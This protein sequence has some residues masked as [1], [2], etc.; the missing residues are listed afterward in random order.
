MSDLLAGTPSWELRV[1]RTRIL[2]SIA[3][4]TNAVGT[5]REEKPQ[6]SNAWVMT[7]R[8]E[9]E[10]AMRAFQRELPEAAGMVQ[11]AVRTSWWIAQ[12]WPR[13]PVPW[14]CLMRL[15]CTRTPSVLGLCNDAPPEQEWLPRGPWELL[16]QAT[17]HAHLR[18]A[19]HRM[20]QFLADQPHVAFDFSRW[21]ASRAPRGSPLLV[22]PLY[23]RT[24]QY[25][26][27]RTRAS[28]GEARWLNP[29]RDSVTRGMAQEEAER[30]LSG[31]F[32]HRDHSREPTS[33]LDLSYLAYA[34][35]CCAEFTEGARVFTELGPYMTRQPWVYES[36]ENG[37]TQTPEEAF[38]LARRQ[39]LSYAANHRNP[40]PG[41]PRWPPHP[42]H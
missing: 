8:V 39:C 29:W 2:G 4:R 31:W 42:D 26:W 40:P 35:W 9:T 25:H 36:D 20:R 18:E 6:S 12:Q 10:R 22:L 32:D 27:Q 7:A 24:E 41:R 14:I 19:Y 37:P 15:C 3:A 30:A 28:T 16:R 17:Q 21:A 5:W 33:H 1:S 13:D 38:T 34:L 23:A 11:S